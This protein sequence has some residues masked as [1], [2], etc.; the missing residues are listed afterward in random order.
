MIIMGL[1]SNFLSYFSLD[2]ELQ[3]LYLGEGDNINNT[4]NNTN[5]ETKTT[6]NIVMSN[7]T[8]SST[9]RSI[10][11]YSTAAIHM[12]VTR[13]PGK[14]FSKISTGLGAF[15]IDTGGKIIEN[16]IN[17]PSYIRDHV[18]NWRLIWKKDEMGNESND[19][20]E[21]DV[22]NDKTLIESVQNEINNGSGS[23]D[24]AS[25][26][27]SSNGNNSELSSFIDELV[28]PIIKALKPQ[29]I[30]YPVE[31]LMD[32]HHIIS[33]CLFI[34]TISALFIFIVFLYNIILFIYK[35]K[36]LSFFTN[37]YIVIYLK[38]QFKILNIEIIILAL[39]II[40]YFY[41][42][43]MGLH[44]LAVFPISVNI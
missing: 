21:L 16:I 6:R 29:Q 7:G 27:P 38:L 34:M 1:I 15:A 41:F 40:Y 8:W 26:L 43:I 33:I 10:F 35:D 17:D 14:G 37:K 36:I 23:S 25:F 28:L 42:L 44:F 32:Q 4:N 2:L 3:P 18:K 22:S 5:N 9:V 20:V 19:T 24:V 30:N 31:L 13:A 39:L 12:H 11:I